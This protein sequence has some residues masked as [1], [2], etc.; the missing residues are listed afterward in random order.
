MK[1][2]ELIKDLEKF[3]EDHGDLEVNRYNSSNDRVSCGIVQ[4]RY[5]KILSKRE[6][7]PSFWNE[8]IDSDDKKGQ[9]V[10]IIL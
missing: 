5:I 8:F 2:S 10:V 1:I 4:E 3:K 6:S 9:K 7:K